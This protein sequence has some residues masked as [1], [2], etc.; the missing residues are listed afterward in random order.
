MTIS[1]Y[2]TP[3]KAVTIEKMVP[4]VLYVPFIE[5]HLFF[6]MAAENPNWKTWEIED[7]RR[8]WSLPED[9]ILM[10]L[11]TLPGLT[12]P[13]IAKCLFGEKIVGVLRRRSR[14]GIDIEAIFY[15][16]KRL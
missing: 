8:L 2:R 16:L 6:D 15:Q 11:G 4:G 12:G 1:I 9:S 13:R 5:G 3:K 14:T 10:Y 7:H